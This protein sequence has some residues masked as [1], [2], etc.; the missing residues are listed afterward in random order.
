MCRWREAAFLLKASTLD[1][2]EPLFRPWVRAYLHFMPCF[3][4]LNVV[5]DEVARIRHH[6]AAV[7]NVSIHELAYPPC[8][9]NDTKIFWRI[10]WPMMW[11]DN[12]TTA[13]HIL[14]LDVDTPLIMAPRCHHLFDDDERPILRSWRW[15]SP[16]HWARLDDNY[17]VRRGLFFPT[18][19]DFM[20]FFPVV[21]PRAVLPLARAVMSND[22][23]H[24]RRCDFDRA[25]LAHPKPA[26]ADL[27]AKTALLLT[28]G[29]ARWVHCPSVS[30]DGGGAAPTNECIDFVPVAEHTKHPT[31]GAHTRSTV[32]GKGHAAARVY[33]DRLFEESV[34][35]PDYVF[36]Y[37]RNRTH[38]QKKRIGRALAAEDGAA[39]VCGAP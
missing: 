28:P 7:P 34:L 12:F 38:A 35:L 13:R 21:I 31:Q 8:Y 30:D 17:F 20:T 5:S 24:C 27:I 36:H 15:R 37:A 18:G 1:V 3:P 33:A 39:R 29:R 9:T 25:F 26:Y 4:Q 16:L 14:V 23:R 6:F 19:Y 10:Q 2:E 22:T 32:R 11:A